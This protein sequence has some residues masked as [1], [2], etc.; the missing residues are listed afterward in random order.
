MTSK[1]ERHRHTCNAFATHIL[2]KQVSHMRF[3]SELYKNKRFPRQPNNNPTA[4]FRSVSGIRCSIAQRARL[5]GWVLLVSLLSI[6]GCSTTQT[7][8]NSHKQDNHDGAHDDMWAWLFGKTKTPVSLTPEE[9]QIQEWR[10]Q[11]EKNDENLIKICN[12]MGYSSEDVKIVTE[13][14]SITNQE[15]SKTWIGYIVQQQQESILESWGVTPSPYDA[16]EIARAWQSAGYG[17]ADCEKAQIY[18]DLTTTEE[19]CAAI[20]YWLLLGKTDVLE[21]VL[22]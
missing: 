3:L 13:K 15:N 19:G 12:D 4:N 21:A 11:A 17:R 16:H 14:L 1:I 20:G 6:D 22:R 18:F 2:D 5:R 10:S 8:R 7:Q 9:Q